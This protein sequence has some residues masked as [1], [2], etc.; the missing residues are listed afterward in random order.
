MEKDLIRLLRAEE[1]ECRIAIVNEKG[2]SLLLYK[3]AR[4]DQ[5]I[6]DET[7]G[8]FGWKRSHQCID[9]N[10]YCTVEILDRESGEWV[11]KQDV[12]TT[13]YTE[14][15]KSQASDSFKR[16]CFNWG[17]GRELYSAPFIWIPAAKT[18]IQ[19]KGDKYISNERFSVGAIS[20]NDNREIVFLEIMDSH[21]QVVYTLGQGNGIHQGDRRQKASRKEGG[22]DQGRHQDKHPVQE[23]EKAGGQEMEPRD[24]Q[25]GGHN[26]D[27]Q[28]GGDRKYGI[29]GPQEIVL[30]AEL[31]RTG[32]ALEEVLERYGIGDIS[33]M[34]PIIYNKAIA[35]LKQTKPKGRKSGTAA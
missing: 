23:Q 2:L 3:D 30:M 31:N 20:F 33:Q 10:L 26:P 13:G 24:G 16:A 9:G 4:V 5:R 14:K 11:S 17:I 22:A 6:L 1:I 18:S 32:V 29:S 12:G 35:A 19:K 21:G 15:E 7:F 28:N 34:T 27:P 25:K 8:A